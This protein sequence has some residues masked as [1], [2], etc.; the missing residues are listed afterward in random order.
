MPAS[1]PHIGQARTARSWASADPPVFPEACP[2]CG[3]AVQERP[4]DP[5]GIQVQYVC[6]GAYRSLSQ[7]QTHTDV[8]AGR[9][10]QA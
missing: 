2:A 3:A 7:I 5:F 10:G 4:G 1:Y 6:G 9:C 8:W